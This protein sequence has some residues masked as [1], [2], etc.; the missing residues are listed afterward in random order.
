MQRL[1]CHALTG[2]SAAIQL[3]LQ[4][5]SSAP[6]AVT[7]QAQLACSAS[8]VPHLHRRQLHC[9]SHGEAAPGG[10]VGGRAGHALALAKQ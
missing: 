9:H 5:S 7:R 4:G 10:A 3:G 1:F 6:H 2:H 8:C